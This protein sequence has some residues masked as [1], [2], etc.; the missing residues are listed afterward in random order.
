MQYISNMTAYPKH[1]SQRVFMN[2][3]GNPT[4]AIFLS[5]QKDSIDFWR[6]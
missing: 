5:L 2:F 1:K 4:V 3:Y 6:M